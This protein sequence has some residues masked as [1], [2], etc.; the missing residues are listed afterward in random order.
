[1]NV[2]RHGVR[3]LVMALLVGASSAC[4]SASTDRAPL[5]QAIQAVAASLPALPEVP[6]STPAPPTVSADVAAA[7]IDARHEPCGSTSRLLSSGSG[8]QRATDDD[9]VL[10]EYVTFARSGRMLDSSA[11]HDEPIDESVRNLAPGLGC[12]VKRM[13]V[14]EARRVWLPATLTPLDQEGPRTVAPVDLTVDLTLRKLI[15]AP[16]RPAEYAAPPRSAQHTATGLYFKALHR[17]TGQTHPA[18]N[19]R[20]TIY[21]SGWT[22][23]GELFESSVFAGHPASYLTYELPRGLSE[24]IQLMRVGDKARFWLPARLAYAE[25]HRSAPKGPVVFDVELL[26]ID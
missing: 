1:M 25:A 24:G 13:S 12:V 16:Q 4:S 2:K 15:Q 19:S 9:R 22:D 5:A 8:E 7:P 17:G 26:A 3:G 23:R 10:L 11:R 20:V 21:H 14:G 6:A 18:A